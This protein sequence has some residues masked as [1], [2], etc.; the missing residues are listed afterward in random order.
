MSAKI[1][2]LEFDQLNN[3]LAKT[4][5]PRFE[6]LGYLGEYFKVMGHQPKALNAF[7]DFTEHSKNGM[8]QK[9]VEVISLTVASALGNDYERNQHERLSVRLG[10]GR[11]W[12]LAIEKRQPENADISDDER[13]LQVFTL[14]A[15]SQTG[16]Q[17]GD[18]FD[19]LVDALGHEQAIAA[20]LLIGRYIGNSAYK[21]T[22]IR[23]LKG[24]IGKITA[25]LGK[26]P[27]IFPV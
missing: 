4:L 18:E 5:A 9:L 24:E 2:R 22:N 21:P 15:L 7:I 27:C 1:P 13:A 10:Y 12:V 20:L 25:Y 8:A 14:K 23:V 11:D 19:Q 16:K 26:F 6:R 17:T 3:E